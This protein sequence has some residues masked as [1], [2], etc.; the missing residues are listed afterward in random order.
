LGKFVVFNF[1]R[2]LACLYSITVASQQCHSGYSTA[3]SGV[4]LGRELSKD[5]MISDYKNGGLNIIDFK[6]FNY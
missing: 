6:S 3:L 1:N 5:V 4:E 2:L